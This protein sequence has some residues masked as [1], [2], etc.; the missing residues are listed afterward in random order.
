MR[1]QIWKA[2]H[3]ESLSWAI[4]A[5]EAW[6]ASLSTDLPIAR[7]RSPETMVVL[8]GPTQV[9][10]TTLLLTLLG[11]GEGA[12]LAAVRQVLRAGRTLGQ[13]STAMPMRYVRSPDDHWRIGP[14]DSAALAEATVCSHLAA[15]RRDVENGT[16]QETDLLSLYIPACYFADGNPPVKVSVLDLPGI[17][18][19]APRE[20]EL[21][22]RIAKRYVPAASLVLLVSTANRLDVF[23]PEHLGKELE[24]LKGWMRSPMRYRLVTTYAYSLDSVRREHREGRLCDLAALRTSTLNELRQFELTIEETLGDRIYPLEYGNSWANLAST[25]PEY[26]GWAARVQA[27]S[28]KALLDDIA[29]S[30]EGETRLRISREVRAE[31]LGRR[32]ELWSEWRDARKSLQDELVVCRSDLKDQLE[33]QRRWDRRRRMYDDKLVQMDAANA[34][35]PEEVIAKFGAATIAPR[36]PGARVSA[37]QQWMRDD[38]TKLVNAC[39][40]VSDW[41][42]TKSGL[43]LDPVILPECRDV[44]VLRSRLNDYTSDRYWTLFSRKYNSD[45]EELHAAAEAHR[46]QAIIAVSLELKAKCQ[47]ARKTPATRRW[48]AAKRCKDLGAEIARLRL[49]EKRILADRKSTS[50][51]YLGKLKTLR[52]DLVRVAEF[53]SHMQK[54]FD[55]ENHRIASCISEA[56]HIGC[57][58][59]AFVRLCQ[60]RLTRDVFHLYCTSAI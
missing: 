37:M 7:K 16:Q 19:A 35:A 17:S 58:S 25:D 1:S 24:E 5:N 38:H 28:R 4:E 39:N 48:L 32:E 49:A 21:V 40:E 26:H 59:L 6:I 57:A 43:D 33:W 41:F 22:K 31:V 13:S 8:F 15:A 20:Q 3:A 54:A 52:S 14:A 36:P 9:G 11:V 50:D 53:D 46:Q 18:A 27:E 2:F 56:V 47:A 30:C 55:A 44:A 34:R 10:K 29:R 51:R 42:N 45:C 60:L 23:S 12:S